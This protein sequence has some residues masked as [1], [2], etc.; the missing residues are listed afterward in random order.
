VWLMMWAVWLAR[1]VQK[2]EQRDGG[3]L[4]LFQV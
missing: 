2:A 3:S 4:G 1:G